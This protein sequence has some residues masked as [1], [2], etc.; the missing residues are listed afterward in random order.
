[1]ILIQCE[2]G[3]AEW[4]KARAGVITASK[5]KDALDTLK[6]GAPSEKSLTYSAEV[7]LE[8]ISG[9]PCDDTFL[10]WQ[11]KRGTELE[12]EAR[13][14]YEAAT[15]M[16]ASESGVALSDDRVYGYSTDGLC[17][18]D[19]MIEV[20]C[21]SSAKVLI[22]M[23]RDQDLSAYIHQMQGGMWITGRKWCD[24]IM[25]A[26]QLASVGKQLFIKRV[27]R[28]EAFIEEMAAGLARFA[29]TVDDNERILRLQAA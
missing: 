7:A 25:Y 12:P 8:R 4:K 13:F 18:D 22:A 15:G 27:M 6:N 9:E 1:M 19:G 26:P 24:F 5:F 29:A 20:K 10:T 11:M 17:D 21:P 2:Q 23:W 14:G 28:D 3:T 16:L